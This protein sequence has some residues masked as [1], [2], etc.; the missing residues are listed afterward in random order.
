VVLVEASSIDYLTLSQPED[1]SHSSAL[2]VVTHSVGKKGRE[3]RRIGY[4]GHT[5]TFSADGLLGDGGSFF[6]GRR[7]WQ[8]KRWH[9]LIASGESAHWLLERLFYTDLMMWSD[10][11]C[12]R[13]DIQ[14]T[15][16]WP[17]APFFLRHL[18]RKE[19]I[20]A[21]VVRGLNK[22]DDWS[23][24]LYLGS[25]ASACLVRAYRKRVDESEH[26]WLRVEV[27]YKRERSKRLFHTLLGQKEVGN[28][29][30]PVLERCPELYGL[31]EPFLADEAQ[32]PK[33]VRI[34][35]KTFKWLNTTV[36]NCVCRLLDDDDNHE[37][38]VELVEQWHK[39]SVSCQNRR[40]GV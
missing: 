14:L 38:M 29:F 7:T 18:E 33:E 1:A 30:L 25:R 9:L 24:T 19:G 27:E 11:R 3:G 15:I 37:A 22:E 20:K 13:L 34:P 2:Q 5:Y 10:V 4:Q 31:I 26:D 17:G 40:A 23:E 39:Y 6:F 16:P 21:S 32:G 35:H 36:A 28:W 8:G 12:T